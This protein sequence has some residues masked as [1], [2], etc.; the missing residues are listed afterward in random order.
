MIQLTDYMKLKKENQSV[1][2]S[3]LLRRG[4]KT[5]T[6]D[7]GKELRGGEEGKG[8]R[9]PCERRLGEVQEVRKLD[10]HVTV[11]NGELGAAS[12]KSQMSGKQEILRTQQG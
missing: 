12:R 3:V 11:G 8:G 7:R 5:I 4:N 2:A 9:I 1:D 10:G 6:G